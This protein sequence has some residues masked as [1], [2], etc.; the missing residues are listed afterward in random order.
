MGQRKSERRFMLAM[1]KNGICKSAN[2]FNMLFQIC[3]LELTN[4]S[5]CN[6]QLK[7]MQSW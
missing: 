2:M 5:I 4:I 1:Q 7:D 6:A 3:N